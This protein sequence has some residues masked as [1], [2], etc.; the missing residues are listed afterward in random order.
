VIKVRAAQP[1]L[2]KELITNA[3]G[4]EPILPKQNVAGS[5]SAAVLRPGRG[6]VAPRR[7]TIV[8]VNRDL[9]GNK[10]QG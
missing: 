3:D 2:S 7:R 5:N 8:S 10:Q 4:L 6:V 1:G 9:G